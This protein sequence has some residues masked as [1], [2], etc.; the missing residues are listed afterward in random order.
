MSNI[1]CCCRLLAG[2]R[3]SGGMF[4]FLIPFAGVAAALAY[5]NLPAIPG[6]KTVAPGDGECSERTELLLAVSPGI[7]MN[8]FGRFKTD[9]NEPN[10]T[11]RVNQVWARANADVNKA[12]GDML[13]GLKVLIPNANT[14]MVFSP[15]QVHEGMG[16]P[17]CS[18]AISRGC[19]DSTRR[20]PR[21]RAS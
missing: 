6:G 12:F 5:M 16:H 8:S 11:L 21:I 19:I 14:L 9:Y 15:W 17:G 13:R 1:V 10:S 2:L 20:L 3:F 4:L 18:R 7:S